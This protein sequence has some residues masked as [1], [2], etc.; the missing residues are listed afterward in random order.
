MWDEPV[1][2]R[3]I[4]VIGDRLEVSGW[5]LSSQV[6]AQPY[7]SIYLDDDL[8]QQAPAITPRPD[9]VAAL[10]AERTGGGWSASIDVAD[11]TWASVEIIAEDGV[12]RRSLDRRTVKLERVAESMQAGGSGSLD[13][14]VDGDAIAGRVVELAGWCRFSGSETDVVEVYVDGEPAGYL[15]PC[16]PRPDVLAANGGWSRTALTSG[17]RDLVVIPPGPAARQAEIFVRVRATDGRVWQSASVTV[18]VDA[19]PS[20]PVAHP[21]LGVPDWAARPVPSAGAGTRSR[22]SIGVLTHSLA[23]G[24]GEL[25]LQELL[26]R[27]AAAEFADFFVISPTDGPL[28]GELEAAGIDVH[29]T[30]EYSVHPMYYGGR[31]AEI[32]ALLQARRCTAVLANTVGVFPAVDAALGAGLPVIWAIHESFDLAVWNHLNWGEGG[33]PAEIDSRMV[34]ALARAETVFEAEATLRLYQ[35]QIPSLRGRCV[36]YG[37]D[38]AAIADY[39]RRNDRGD[40]RRELGFAEGQRVILCMGVFQERKAQLALVNAFSQVVAAHPT[41]RLALVGD[42]PTRY[43]AAIHQLV[44]HGLAE[45]VRILP[46]QPD[47]YRWYQAADILVSA[48]DVESLPRSVLESMA[49]GLPTLATDVFGLG[50]VIADGSTGWLCEPRS[51]VSLLAGLRRVLAVTDDELAE[52]SARCLRQSAE[53]DGNGYAEEYLRL[54]VGGGLSTGESR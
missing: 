30:R 43:S 37:I 17:F 48:S 25:Y 13:L 23:L 19:R 15:R 51:G 38:L 50:E 11:R 4:A 42:H 39:R 18:C 29:I 8:V 22:P 1:A 47:I 34:D 21:S 46:I 52:F 27:L 16:D 41:V 45:S 2:G 28:R 31:A 54:L 26:M 36:R 35:R 3:S 14:P 5:A 6:G 20:R 24:G 49:F 33:L 9:V 40:V 53:F 32:A 44:D 7:V 12:H 10:G